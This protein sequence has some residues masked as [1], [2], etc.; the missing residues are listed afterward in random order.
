MGETTLRTVCRRNR[1]PAS[2]RAPA[3]RLR[4]ASAPAPTT[5]GRPS[6][7]P[8]GA[9]ASRVRLAPRE[10]VEA[11][12][13]REAGDAAGTDPRRDQQRPEIA[14]V[15]VHLVV[16]HLGG[17]AHAEAKRGQLE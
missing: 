11:E 9:A 12:L 14:D 4:A 13:V 17:R 6:R 7:P 16:V 3:A 10:R 8:A 2:A 15:V 5:V 1:R